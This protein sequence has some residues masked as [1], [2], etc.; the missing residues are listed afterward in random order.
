MR[1]TGV[2]KILHLMCWEED[3]RDSPPVT[4]YND[5]EDS[6]T[7]TTISN[8]SFTFSDTEDPTKQILLIKTPTPFQVYYEF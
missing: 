7:M 8:T 6:I 3:K 5:G 2:L 1:T 4:L